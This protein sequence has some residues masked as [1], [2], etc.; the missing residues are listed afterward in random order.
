QGTLGERG[1][2]YVLAQFG[3][4]FLVAVDGAPFVDDGDARLVVLGLASIAAGLVVVYRAAS[5]LG[6]NLSPWP[7]PSDPKSGRGSLV[8]GGIYAYVRHPMYS[9]LLLGM[10]G[11]GL[12]TDSVARLFLTMVLAIVL[13]AKSDYEEEKL[14]EAYGEEYEEYRRE[15]RGKFLPRYSDLL[16]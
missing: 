10:T 15:V 16:R 1:E 6:G 7:V 9:G 4:L 8:G 2:A 12:V 3:L 11:L 5:D 14:K 13:D